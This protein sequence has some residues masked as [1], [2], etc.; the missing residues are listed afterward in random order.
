MDPSIIDDLK[1]E[2][3]VSGLLKH[4]F[5]TEPTEEF[6]QIFVKQDTIPE[7][8]FIANGFN[9]IVI[10]VNRNAHR[11]DE[12]L[13][14]LSI[15]FAKLFLGPKNPPA[16]PFS[17][18]Y[19]S[20]PRTLMS[21]VT[22]GV[23]KTYLDAGMEIKY[24]HSIPDDHI[25]I[26]LEFVSCLDG[27]IMELF[28]NGNEEEALKLQAIKDEFLHEHMA[29]WVPS[30]AESVLKYTDYDFYK[31]SALLLKNLV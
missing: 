9:L 22:I 23:R 15:E 2:G 5:W 8:S 30:F 25:G 10:E 4:V 18:C 1:E 11:I 13:N 14:D 20:E 24:L 31:G 26:E 3:D 29:M 21:D 7:E 17:S 28:E 12:Y 27:K 16:V 19:L 6:L